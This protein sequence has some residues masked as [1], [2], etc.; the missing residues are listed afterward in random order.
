MS[1]A[2]L[3]GGVSG[4]SAAFYLSLIDKGLKVKLFE[5]SPR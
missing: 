4:L 2:V 3:G 1:V 5:R